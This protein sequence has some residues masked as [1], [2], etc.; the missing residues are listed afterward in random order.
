[1]R[2]GGIKCLRVWVKSKTCS[3]SSNSRIKLEIKSQDL[4]S[5]ILQ[6][7]VFGSGNVTGND[8]VLYCHG[9]E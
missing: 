7:L 4:K 9:S 8:K 2:K 5:G 1:V 6:W 3:N